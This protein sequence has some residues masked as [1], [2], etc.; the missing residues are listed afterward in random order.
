MTAATLSSALLVLAGLV[1]LA[2]VIGVIS[3]ARVESLSGVTLA[4]RPDLEILLRHRAVLFGLLGAAMLYGAFDRDWFW[5]ALGFG[6]VSM[7]A[8]AVLSAMIG[9]YGSQLKLVLTMDVIGVAFALAAAGA[10]L[11][12][13]SAA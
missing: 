3:A 1:N 8:Y 7:I 12:M 2:P 11:S 4:G 6:L 13:G 10:R 5:P 9:G